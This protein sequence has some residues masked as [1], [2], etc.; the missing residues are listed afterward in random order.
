MWS[1]IIGVLG[2][3]GTWAVMSYL[4]GRGSDWAPRRYWLLGLAGLFPAWLIAFLGLLQSVTKS[5]E[6][7]LPPPAIFSSGA[8]LLGIIV[9]DYL[10]RRAQKSG[11]SFG[12]VT[13]WIIGLAALLPAWCIAVVGRAA[14]GSP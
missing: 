13:C 2:A 7:P 6:A 9:T 10:L 1:I 8:A 4:A 5:V 11:R 12:A 14:T 3:F